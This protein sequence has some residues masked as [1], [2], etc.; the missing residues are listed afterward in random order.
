VIVVLH[1]L[2]IMQLYHGVNKII[3]L[4]KKW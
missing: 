2:E 4:M 3:Y 1:K